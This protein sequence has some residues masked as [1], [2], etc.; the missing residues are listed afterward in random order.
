MSFTNLCLRKQRYECH[1][2]LAACPI[3]PTL[4]PFVKLPANNFSATLF[5]A[6]HNLVEIF[7]RVLMNQTYPMILFIFL[8]LACQGHIEFSHS[9]RTSLQNHVAC[10]YAG[11]MAWGHPWPSMP[12]APENIKRHVTSARR[13]SRQP[14]AVHARISISTHPP[15]A[16][17][18][19]LPSE[20]TCQR[21]SQ[22]RG[23][24]PLPSE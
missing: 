7:C 9:S 8:R 18:R 15:F 22:S 12:C 19:A 16:D 21:A 4:V 24:H 23:P 11:R 20:P 1:T 6:C 5:V 13:R 17:L 14:S 3:C 2:F 10:E